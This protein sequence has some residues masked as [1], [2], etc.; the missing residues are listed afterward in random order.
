MAWSDKLTKLNKI[1]A[2]IYPE[3]SQSRRVVEMAGIPVGS[4]S[5]KDA[6]MD[7]WY[8]I[9]KEA[10]NRKKVDDL[11]QVVLQEYPDREDLKKLF[12]M[13]SPVV[14]D[15]PSS[16]TLSVRKIL[17]L[18]A[19]PKR[20][21]QL[22]L[23][24][25]LRKVKDSLALST[26]RDQF[27]LESES[28]VKISTITKAMQIQKPEIV[29]FAAHGTKYEGIVVEDDLGGVV[30][31]PVAGLD[32]LFRSFKDTVKCV[33]LNACHS[34]EQAEAISKH[35]IYVVG[36]NK[37]IKDSAAIDF[38]TGFY[39][40]LGEGKEYEFAFNMALVNNSANLKDADTPELWLNGNKLDI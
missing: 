21:E 28:A 30:L 26:F 12:A 22:R 40:S 19:N 23:G 33:V 27:K 37:A 7:N 9:L 16:P 36:M 38:A 2:E 17:F 31:F 13:H 32:R 15:Q 39:Q 3:K 35:G 10:D 6:V 4:I 18:S 11:V 8:Y 24:E 25:E 5:F 29:H 34:K 1:L 14:P 20:Q